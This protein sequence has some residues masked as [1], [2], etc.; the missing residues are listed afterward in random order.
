[1]TTTFDFV[2]HS[3]PLWTVV[4]FCGIPPGV[5]DCGHI[6]YVVHSLPFGLWS[7]S[8][9]YLQVLWIVVTYCM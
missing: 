8:V 4:T 1:M 6:L 2:V 3:Q 5:V 7:L 9:V